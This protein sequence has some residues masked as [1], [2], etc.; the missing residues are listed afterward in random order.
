[1]TMPGSETDPPSGDSLTLT[2]PA[3][4]DAALV[5][6]LLDQ[7]IALANQDAIAASAT[8][9]SLVGFR[10]IADNLPAL[11][12]AV[13]QDAFGEAEA[14]G[15]TVIA[16]EVSGVM[17]VDEGLRCWGFVSV[18]PAPRATPEP[19]IADVPEITRDGRMLTAVI[20]IARSKEIA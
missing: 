3:I 18:V 4:S 5:Q 12:V 8:S 17:A 16:A 19:M 20:S 1:M 7:V 9:A 14:H 13:V 10:S 11:L 6:A 15:A 2:I